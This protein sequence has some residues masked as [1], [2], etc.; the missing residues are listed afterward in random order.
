LKTQFTKFGAV[1]QVLPA[2]CA[3]NGTEEPWSKTGENL[4]CALVEFEKQ[5]SAKKAVSQ[6]TAFNKPGK[7]GSLTQQQHMNGKSKETA[8][9]K[10]GTQTVTNSSNSAKSKSDTATSSNSGPVVNVTL[11]VNDAGEVQPVVSPAD[12]A[13]SATQ[14]VS[15]SSNANEKES[16]E[17]DLGQ[18]FAGIR[19]MSWYAYEKKYGHF[20]KQTNNLPVVNNNNTTTQQV[21]SVQQQLPKQKNRAS[22]MNWRCEPISNP[23]A[24]TATGN[25]NYSMNASNSALLTELSSSPLPLN[26]HVQAHV[27]TTNGARGSPIL[28]PILPKRVS[29]DTVL[30]T[31]D[32]SKNEANGRQDDETAA[33]DKHGRRRSRNKGK[34]RSR[35]GS[36]ED[37]KPETPSQ[38]PPELVFKKRTTGTGPLRLAAGPDDT[39][40]F[41]GRGRGSAR[42]ISN[43]PPVSRDSGFGHSKPISA[44]A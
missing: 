25:V 37:K 11:H 31:A 33:T 8:E 10:S 35:T 9:T 20:E 19:I 26:N 40:G 17:W 5:G 6:I 2:Y 3:L 16:K 14:S 43:E 15:S 28:R 1:V 4:R 23:Q 41:A 42:R 34:S 18:A 30:T 13:K 22:E 24:T 27:V 38:R 21:S 36:V 7:R 39:R 29:M 32:E 12:G 44:Q